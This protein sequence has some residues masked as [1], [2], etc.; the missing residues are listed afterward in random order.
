MSQEVPKRA[1]TIGRAW[2]EPGYESRG[3]SLTATPRPSPSWRPSKTS[4]WSLCLAPLMVH[5]P[6]KR[7]EW[8]GWRPWWLWIRSQV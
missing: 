8:R 1:P 7:R 5:I 6:V 4:K 3:Q 2:V